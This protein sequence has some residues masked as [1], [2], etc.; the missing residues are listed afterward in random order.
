VI[1]ACGFVYVYVLG[2]HALLLGVIV[3]ACAGLSVV[4][5]RATVVDGLHVVG[6]FAWLNW[7]SG[8]I[9]QGGSHTVNPIE[10]CGRM[11]LLGSL[12][13]T[14]MSQLILWPN[15]PLSTIVEFCESS[16]NPLFVLHAVRKFDK[17]L[18][19]IEYPALCCGANQEDNG[20][21]CASTGQLRSDRGEENA[22]VERVCNLVLSHRAAAVSA[23][24]STPA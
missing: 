6:S 2:I 8:S 16:Y 20:E 19:Q 4:G 10:L 3:L 24:T 14:L 12:G 22:D 23:C 15:V 1:S 18:D 5:A 17:E 21:C 7:V 13:H 9:I 11:S